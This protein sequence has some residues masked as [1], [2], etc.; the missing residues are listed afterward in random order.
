MFLSSLKLGSELCNTEPVTFSSNFQRRLGKHE[1]KLRYVCH[2]LPQ[3]KSQD[4]ISNKPMNKNSLKQLPS[5]KAQYYIKTLQQQI[6]FI[7]VSDPSNK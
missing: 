5:R 3:N 4:I 7:I 2:I 1:R 6:S